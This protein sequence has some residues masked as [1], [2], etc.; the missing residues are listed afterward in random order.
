M[1]MA[2]IR[3][4]RN[5]NIVSYESKSHYC[6]ATFTPGN[7][8]QICNLFSSSSHIHEIFRRFRSGGKTD[9]W[10][11]KEDEQNSGHNRQQFQHH[12]H[13]QNQ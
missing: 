3:T 8:Y 11:Q 12:V 9:S 1:D 5:K 2:I 6:N 10:D 7:I 13:R 4:E